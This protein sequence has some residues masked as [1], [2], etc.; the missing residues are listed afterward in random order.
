MKFTDSSGRFFTDYTSNCS[1][2]DN[3]QKKYAPDSTQNNFRI[4]LQHN[5]ENIMNEMANK[6]NNMNSTKTK[7]CPICSEKVKK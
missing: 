4:Y 6:E 5:A 3:L 2:Y 7:V 1:M